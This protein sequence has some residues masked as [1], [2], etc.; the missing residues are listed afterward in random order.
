MDSK[1]LSINKLKD[2]FFS[3]KINKSSGVAGIN[4]NVMKKNALGCFA[5]PWS[6]YFSYIFKKGAF[7]DELK[8]EKV[9]PIYKGGDISNHRPITVLPGFSKILERL[10]YNHV[11]IT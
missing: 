2:D 8:I 11:T 6:T 3:L 7:T 5:N 4:F 9:T 1:T 10:I